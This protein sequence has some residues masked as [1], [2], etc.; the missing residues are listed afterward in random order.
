MSSLNLTL[1]KKTYLIE[2]IS[3]LRCLDLALTFPQIFIFIGQ[4]GRYIFSIN[5]VNYTCINDY[6][7]R[8]VFVQMY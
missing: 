2:D 6:T 5:R 7:F 1:N 8:Y 4:A 3:R